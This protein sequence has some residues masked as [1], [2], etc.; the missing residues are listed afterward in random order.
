MVLPTS[1]PRVAASSWR[2]TQTE[3]FFVSSAWSSA[4]PSVTTYWASKPGIAVMSFVVQSAAVRA[5]TSTSSMASATS[6]SPALEKSG[7]TPGS[8]STKYSSPTA[9]TR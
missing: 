8:S 4:R 2:M 6:A 5:F 7:S 1:S 9:G 3:F